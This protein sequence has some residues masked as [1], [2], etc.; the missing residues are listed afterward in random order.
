MKQRVDASPNSSS[1][2]AAIYQTRDS[3]CQTLKIDGLAFPDNAH[4]PT[5]LLE[6]V[7]R[8]S[9]TSDIGFKLI[10]PKSS[11]DFR[12]RRSRAIAMPVPKAAVNEHDCSKTREHNVRRTRQVASVKTESKSQQVRGPADS[13]LRRRTLAANR[14]HNLATQGVDDRASPLPFVLV[15]NHRWP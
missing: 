11:A 8:P 13:Q 1:R 7:R 5:Q 4:S 15:R 2:F 10:S 3:P 6:I 14:A 12:S 9:I